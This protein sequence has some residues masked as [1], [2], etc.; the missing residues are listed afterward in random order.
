MNKFE[1]LILELGD[2]LAMTLEPQKGRLVSL[3]INGQMNLNIE[4][5]EAKDMLLLGCLICDVPPG[6]YKEL[7]FKETLRINGSYP[8]PGTFAYSE[9]NNKLSLFTYLSFE[10][11]TPEKLAEKIEAF[12]D[13]CDGWRRAADSGNLSDV[14][15]PP[16]VSRPPPPGMAR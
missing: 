14:A 2:V 13:V 12:L 10:K 4:F 6:R 8:R 11:L 9:R 1:T 5:D 15:L 7:L 16:A 3:S